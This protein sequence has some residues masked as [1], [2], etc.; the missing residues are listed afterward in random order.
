MIKL[1]ASFPLQAENKTP[2]NRFHFLAATCLPKSFFPC[3]IVL[4]KRH[5]PNFS[6]DT[7]FHSSCSHLLKMDKLQLFNILTIALKFLQYRGKN[8]D[9]HKLHL[10]A[11]EKFGHPQKSIHSPGKNLNIPEM[12]Q[13]EEEFAYPRNPS[14]NSCHYTYRQR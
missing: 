12:Q 8:A 9:I 4:P 3:A 6:P 13:P 2:L 10:T 11:G 1:T 14:Y 7:N 5:F